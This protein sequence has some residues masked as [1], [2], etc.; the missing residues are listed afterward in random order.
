MLMTTCRSTFGMSAEET[1]T[2]GKV[3]ILSRRSAACI[4]QIHEH[5]YREIALRRNLSKLDTRE[6]SLARSV[7]IDNRRKLLRREFCLFRK[8][9]GDTDRPLCQPAG[10]V[11]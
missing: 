9:P 4:R 6:D 10:R 8:R 11:V 7:A 2:T 3:R 5:A 1:K